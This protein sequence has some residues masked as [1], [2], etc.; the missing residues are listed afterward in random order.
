MPD[1]LERAWTLHVTELSADHVSSGSQATA[2]SH[3]DDYAARGR[4]LT[5]PNLRVLEEMPLALGYDL[6]YN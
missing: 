4:K 6:C 5:R 1:A 2:I 3:R